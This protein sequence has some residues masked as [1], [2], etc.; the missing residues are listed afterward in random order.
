MLLEQE[1]RQD[2]RHTFSTKSKR[3]FT[4]QVVVET[5]ARVLVLLEV[6]DTCIKETVKTH[7]SGYNSLNYQLCW[8]LNC[9]FTSADLKRKT[10]AVTV[11]HKL[12]SITLTHRTISNFRYY[13]LPIRSNFI[14]IQARGN[15][16][17]FFLHVFEKRL[18]LECTFIK[19][20]LNTYFSDCF[21]GAVV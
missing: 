16:L 21:I 13:L 3:K 10:H 20:F 9:G 12:E 8:I 2:A 14:N 18:V 11:L 17:K 1:E 4:L 7:K 6:E 19:L 5:T 15:C